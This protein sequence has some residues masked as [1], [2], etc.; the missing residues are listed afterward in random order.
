MAGAWEAMVDDGDTAGRGAR[1]TP[2]HLDTAT[3][4]S[5]TLGELLREL[6]GSR[7]LT[8][9]ALADLTGLSVRTLR[10][11]ESGR[12]SRPRW[13]TVQRLIDGL[14]L[15]PAERS[16]FQAALT[17]A[18]PTTTLPPEPSAYLTW[19]P[20]DVPFF[21]GRVQQLR[22]LDRLA[23]RPD[24]AA[25]DLRTVVISGAAGIGKSALALH[26]GH[27][28]ADAFPDG[29]LYVNLR[30]YD[31]SGTPVP[32][33]DAIKILLGALAVPSPRIPSGLTERMGLYRTLT[34]AK[35]ILIVIDN[36]RDAD[37]VRPLLPNGTNSRVLIT[38]RNPMVGLVATDAARPI[39]LDVLS[40]EEARELLLQRLGKDHLAGQ[41]EAVS[42]IVA[43]CAGLPLALALVAARASTHPSH[44][45]GD[46]AEELRGAA[47]AFDVIVSDDSASDLRTV[48]SWSYRNLAEEAASTFRLLGVHPGPDISLNAVASL[49][50]L[51]PAAARPL[52]D[53]ITAA[54]LIVEAVAGRFAMHDLIRAYAEQLSGRDSPEQRGSATARVL[55]HYLRTAVAADRKVEPH[56]DMID[57]V[58]VRDGVTITPVPDR[59]TAQAWLDAEYPVLVRMVRA[60]ATA[61]LDEH[62]WQLAWAMVEYL[63][64]QGYPD[65]LARTQHIA[66]AAARR[67]GNDDAEG[68]AL[69]Y[70]ANADIQRGN[71]DRA[72]QHLQRALHLCAARLDA[73]GQA[74]AHMNLALLRE[75]QERF[76]DANDHALRALELFR[77]AGHRVGEGIALNSLGYGYALAGDLA[78]A[79]RCCTE[80]LAVNTEIDHPKG[81]AHTFDSLGYIYAQLHDFGKAADYYQQALMLF[82]EFGDRHNEADALVNLGDVARDGGDRVAALTA[83]Q[84]AAAILDDLDH[85]RAGQ[86]R[87]RLAATNPI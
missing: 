11:L 17:G 20:P 47:A 79:L 6:R 24:L 46:L 37:Q 44:A 80:A 41:D 38:S 26:W 48:F 3:G 53:Q 5:L 51:A 54:G 8:Q 9:E 33:A 42:D 39:V 29:Q 77:Q 14:E 64:L 74:K 59:Q 19:L 10:Y 12:M 72:D 30:G 62:A 73:A 56:R 58:P 78:K 85:P 16:L 86:V 18:A 22:E 27:R 13:G 7:Q 28:H 45:L 75:L 69:R 81:K 50:G 32:P 36:A 68:L 70:L 84:D 15:T 35:Q 57:M 55:D 66:L 52:L 34:F 49:A 61:G 82:R 60:A 25:E 43:R 40:E 63:D 31:P 71:L 76:G 67:L 83:W 21:V 1:D 23:P 65:D 87:E 4:R 2:G